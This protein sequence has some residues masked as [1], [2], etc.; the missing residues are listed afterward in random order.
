MRLLLR[1]VLRLLVGA[2]LRLVRVG[3]AVRGVHGHRTPRRSVPVRLCVGE[4]GESA[5]VRTPP[6]GCRVHQPQKS[7]PLRHPMGS[8]VPTGGVFDRVA[9]VPG[10][11]AAPA[12][13][14]RLRPETRGMLAARF[15]RGEEAGDRV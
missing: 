9:P 12:G 11:L 1:L 2:A 5:L 13:E 3:G 6:A 15:P 4:C 14:R 8:R 10:G 7:A